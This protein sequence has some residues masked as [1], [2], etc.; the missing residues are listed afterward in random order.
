MLAR[1]TSCTAFNG[2][3]CLVLCSQQAVTADG[4]SGQKAAAA[5]RASLPEPSAAATTGGVDP[6]PSTSMLQLFSAHVP[7]P[8]DLQLSVSWVYAAPAAASS[9]SS[10]ADQQQRQ[11][12][13]IAPPLLWVMTQ[14]GTNTTRNVTASGQKAIHMLDASAE[15]SQQQQ[16]LQPGVMVE[17][18]PGT[19]QQVQQQ[20]ALGPLQFVGNAASSNSN[21]LIDGGTDSPTTYSLW[22][23]DLSSALRGC[24]WRRCSVQL[25]V[26]AGSIITGVGVALE[27]AMVL[28][29]ALKEVQV[30]ALLGQLH[31]TVG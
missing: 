2:G 13:Q 31:L 10:P 19:Q 15:P 25:P 8:Y 28:G 20:D 24:E 29:I 16:G 26:R 6:G 17:A 5:V 1:L 23:V 21:V 22:D 9:S 11:Q 18:V 3:S 27:A 7:V 12:Q 4:V 30:H 14:Q